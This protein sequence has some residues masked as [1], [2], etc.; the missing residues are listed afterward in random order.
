MG[1]QSESRHCDPRP[2]SQLSVS[3][4]TMEISG[5]PMSPFN[6]VYPLRRTTPLGSFVAYQ[7]N[8]S[9]RT[10]ILGTVTRLSNNSVI[11]TDVTIHVPGTERVRYPQLTLP[12]V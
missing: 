4:Q 11:L 9:A 10:V 3:R 12:I 2:M 5:S 1:F 7:C 8:D 6:G